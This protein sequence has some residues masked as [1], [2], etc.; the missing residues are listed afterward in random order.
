MAAIPAECLV[1]LDESGALT[2]L[3]RLD[4]G[5]PRGGRTL[6]TAPGGR[7]ERVT[8]LGALGLEG[9]VG[10]MSIAAATD[11]TVFLAYLEQGLLPALRR[12][13]PDAVLVM[14]NLAV[15]SEEVVHPNG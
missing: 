7:W 13:E 2:N 4:G 1:C 12:V 14:D 8:I 3:A 11:G 6:G 5:S 9:L 15:E 10:T